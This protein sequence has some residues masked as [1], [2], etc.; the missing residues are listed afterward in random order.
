MLQCIIVLA[1]DAQSTRIK[2]MRARK[3]GVNRERLLQD[4]F[5]TLHVTFLN[6]N[7]SLVHVTICSCRIYF[8]CNLKRRECAFQVPL[9][10]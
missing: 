9:Q 3:A 1:F 10:E 8:R 4:L 2:V 6:Q 7:A 5:G